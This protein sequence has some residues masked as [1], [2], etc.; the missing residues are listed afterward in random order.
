[1]IVITL[2]KTPQSL[3][4]D[5]TKWC[6]EVQTGVYVG[7]FSARIRDLI[8][9][10]IISNIGQ[11]EATLIYSTNNELGFDFKTT[12]QDKMVADFDGI[13]LMVH[14]NSQNK[15]SSKK[16]LGF[17]KAAQHHKVNTFRSQVQ[18]KANSLTSL[19]VLDIETTGLN[20]EKDKIIS[21]G[22]IKYLENNDCEKF[23][24]LIKVDT[25][26]PN[27][28]E[29]ITQ[30]N[31]GILANKGIDIKTALLDLRKFLA[32]RIVVGYNLPFDINFLNRDFK[33]YCHYS[34]LN[35]CVD[36]LPAVKKKNVFLDNYHLSTVLENYNIKNLNPHNS[37]AD[38]VVTMELL[39][40]LIKNDNYKI[41]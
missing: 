6:Q 24:R 3:R 20:L 35:E 29:K 21:I 38:A 19:A 17:S 7:N 39:K 9:Q 14:L 36:L 4:G 1:M 12:R 28:I 30:L 15:I 22:A 23:Y 11:G 41:K 18:D 34:L 16:K 5:L 25:E 26:V 33:K 8:W 40:K 37:L 27:N 13:P 32:D 31:K 10:R 2:S